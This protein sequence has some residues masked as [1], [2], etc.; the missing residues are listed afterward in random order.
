MTESTKGVA[1]IL[2]TG[3]IWG[4]M[5]I[6]LKLIDHIPPLE[7]LAHRTLWSLVFF[8]AVLVVQGRPGLLRGAL[9]CRRSAAVLAVAAVLISAN[10]ITFIT[11][12]QWDRA[13]EASLGYF[14]VPLASVLLGVVFFGE[15]LGRAQ[16][17]AVALAAL[18]L[19]LLAFGLGAAPWIALMLA[20]SFG[21]YGAVK[22]SLPVG[23]VVSVTAEV[24]LLSPFALGLLWWI[25]GSGG[26]Y[27]GRGLSDSL[28]LMLS[29][30]LTAVPLMMFSYAARRLRLATLG[31]SQYLNPTLQFL[32]ATLI[33]RE[34]F[35]LWHAAAFPLIWLALA[36][37]TVAFW[38]Q[39]KAARRLA[40]NS[41]T[42]PHTVT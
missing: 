10:W 16:S 12:I 38:R 17:L 29:G 18:A 1:A 8:F 40:R 42:V 41:A 13:T 3:V 19:G 26:G 30:P 20:G 6:Y 21:L 5:S 32:V 24:L 9:T 31:L 23:P 36:I 14:T 33:F 28:L 39:E 25:H 27:F 7:I 4:L 15:R 11:A 34:T 37:Y 35:T 2:G 22:K